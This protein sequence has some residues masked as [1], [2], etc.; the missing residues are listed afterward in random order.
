MSSGWLHANAV[1]AMRKRSVRR[2]AR[3]LLQQQDQ[4]AN[5]NREHQRRERA[6]EIKAAFFNRF[7][8]EIANR[9]A[10][11]S[12]QDKRRPEQGNAADTGPEI[13]GCDDGKRNREYDRCATIAKAAGVSRPVAK[14]GAQRLRKR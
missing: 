12:R 7:V 5:G 11:R 3:P 1:A 4:C 13:Q 6:A 8:E 9:C 2:L 14:G 10:Q